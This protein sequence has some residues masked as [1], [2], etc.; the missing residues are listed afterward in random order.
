LELA[1][2]I[3]L[4]L[5]DT[6]Y[7]GVADGRMDDHLILEVR[8]N[9]PILVVNGQKIFLL[10]QPHFDGVDLLSRLSLVELILPAS[11][12]FQGVKQVGPHMS[13]TS[14]DHSY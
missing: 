1:D 2:L 14:H 8:Q 11:S 9:I 13:A 4:V 12:T 10:L 6:S 3:I 7:L 5:G